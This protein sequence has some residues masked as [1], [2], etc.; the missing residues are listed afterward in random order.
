[1]IERDNKSI[2]NG[3]IQDYKS[4]IIELQQQESVMN[5]SLFKIR[6]ASLN[7]LMKSFEKNIK[8]FY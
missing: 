3:L 1:M 7:N 2:L 5:P 6:M 4:Q 8:N